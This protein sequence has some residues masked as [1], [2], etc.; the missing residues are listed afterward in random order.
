MVTNQD[1]TEAAPVLE[2]GG[3]FDVS[4]LTIAMAFIVLTMVVA[5]LHG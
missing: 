5:A 2:D 1:N 3:G 4:W